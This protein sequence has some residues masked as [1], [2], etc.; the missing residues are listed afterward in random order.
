MFYTMYFWYPLCRCLTV[1]GGVGG[2][3]RGAPQ[4]WKPRKGRRR[5]G[6]DPAGSSLPHAV[7][8]LG[9]RH[10]PRIRAPGCAQGGVPRRRL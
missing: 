7:H 4:H 3:A 10:L 9:E 8:K 1:T 6:Q 2:G 5:N